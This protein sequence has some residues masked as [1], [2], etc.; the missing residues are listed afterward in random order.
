MVAIFVVLTFVGFLAV[1]YFVLK[2]QGKKHPA[3]STYKVFDKKSFFFPEDAYLAPGHTWFTRLDGGNVKI[4]IDEFISKS[5]MD[6]KLI[7]LTEPGTKVKKG[8]YIFEAKFNDSKI[9]FKSPVAG[10]V[11]A[12]NQNLSSKVTDPYGDDWAITLKAENMAESLNFVKTKEAAHKWLNNEFN[13]LKDF[14]D[15]SLSEVQP[16]GATM[17][18][19]G[20]IVEGAL[21]YLSNDAI[22]K[23]EN[24][25]LN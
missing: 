21:S 1:D 22:Q 11:Q 25:F 4:G 24:D 23:F 8:D 14:L 2:A 6:F 18:D 3:F 15:A 5:L 10:T 12:V 20:N 19:G 16:V 17:H 13:R 7:P 9:R